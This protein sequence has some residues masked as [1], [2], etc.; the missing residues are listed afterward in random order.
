MPRH[1]WLLT[2][3]VSPARHPA[4][5]LIP[6]F[7]K[8]VYPWLSRRGVV[9]TMLQRIGIGFALATAG[10]LCAG[11]VEV[12]RLSRVH[13]GHILV[14]RVAGREIVAADLSVFW[15]IPQYALIGASEVFAA[16]TGAQPFVCP[17][18]PC[19]HACCVCQ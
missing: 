13:S 14:Q 19:D 1:R 9:F 8:V 17:H 3:L 5:S 15:Q 2:P 11:L 12:L 6:L 10:V 4:Q 18:G 7:D 16:T